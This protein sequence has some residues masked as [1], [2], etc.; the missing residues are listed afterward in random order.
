MVLASWMTLHAVFGQ[1]AT[2]WLWT[3]QA[4]A[5]T[6]ACLQALMDAVTNTEIGKV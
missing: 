4:A 3:Y 5:K 6:A 1:M 2:L